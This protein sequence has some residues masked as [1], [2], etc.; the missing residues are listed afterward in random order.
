MWGQGRFNPDLHLRKPQ[1]M[2]KDWLLIVSDDPGMLGNCNA[3][4]VRILKHNLLKRLKSLDFSTMRVKKPIMLSLPF[5]PVLDLV[6]YRWLRSNDCADV[7]QLIIIRVVIMYSADV[8]KLPIMVTFQNEVPL[9]PK[10]VS[11]S[12]PIMPV[13]EALE[14]ARTECNCQNLPSKYLG[15]SGH[16]RTADLSYVREQYGDEV[17]DLLAEGTKFRT[18]RDFCMIPGKT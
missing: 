6:D 13:K 17:A 11:N 2:L 1:K 7:Y 16:L 14:L 15:E 10:I 9:Y 3:N 12:F 5:H 18:D 8:G 4:H